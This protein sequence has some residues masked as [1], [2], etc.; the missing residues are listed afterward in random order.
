MF[1]ERN[2]ITYC[3]LLSLRAP[4]SCLKQI[5]DGGDLYVG[6]TRFEYPYGFLGFTQS[7]E[8][9]KHLIDISEPLM[10][11]S[12]IGLQSLTVIHT[13]VVSV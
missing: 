13:S 3:A 9:Y 11:F 5:G 1:T 4:I 12:G 6:G 2:K 8:M 7:F 10:N